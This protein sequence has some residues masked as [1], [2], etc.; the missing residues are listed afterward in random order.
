VSG[1]EQPGAPRVLVVEDDVDVR[2]VIVW[3]L[4]PE[5]KVEV[6]TDGVEGVAAA[7]AQ[8]PDLIVTDIRMPRLSGEEL[9]RQLRSHPELDATSILVLSGQGDDELRVRLL[10]E[11]AQDYI[12]KPFAT[13]ELRARVRNL[14]AAQRSRAMLLDRE[15]AREAAIFEVSLDAII[16]MDHRGIVTGFNPAAERIFGYTRAEALGRPLAE[17]IIPP[18]LRE[19]HRKGMARYL[20]GGRSLMVGGRVEITGMRKD[21]SEFPVE[22]SICRLPGSDPPA[23]TGFLRDLTE[24]KRSAEAQQAAR[25]AAEE[26]VRIRDDFVAVAGHELKTPLAAMLLQ[27]QVLR[28]TIHKAEP[29]DLEER[30]AKIA[31]SGVRLERLVEQLLDVSRITA[32]RLRLEPA[33]C[34]LADIA[35][36]VAE[37]FADVS[38]QA[39]SEVTV[40]TDGHVEGIWDRQRLEAVIANLLS[41][42]LKFGARK[43]IEIV[44]VGGHG[45]A[46]LRVTDHGIGIA[47]EDRPKLFRRFERALAARDYGGFGLGLWICRNIVEASGGTI[48]VESEPDHGST[49]IVR[50][51]TGLSEVAHAAP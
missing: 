14:V 4:A 47:D 50:L 36:D 39:G 32:G 15:A 49:F 46:E 6:A 23:F 25:V 48:Q 18:W 45:Q 41:N 9:V 7:T 42:A 27:I 28:R 17:L 2:R 5:F 51:P 26:A 33:P 43:P 3:A 1:E 38:A 16:S 22:V 20:A 37:R 40:C 19:A 30:V 12:A 31:R 13:G 21:G 34:D 35:R 24:I 29:V 11:G 10:S 8:P 44:V